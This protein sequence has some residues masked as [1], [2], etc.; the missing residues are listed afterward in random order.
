M[1]LVGRAAAVADRNR[2]L[3]T[4]SSARVVRVSSLRP[5][6]TPETSY[7]VNGLYGS[8]TST[9]RSKLCSAIFDIWSSVV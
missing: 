4:H 6:E 9:N 2:D 1:P 7:G 8:A 3:Q 5:G